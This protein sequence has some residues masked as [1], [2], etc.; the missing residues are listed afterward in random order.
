MSRYIESIRVEQGIARNLGF[1]QAR[2]QQTRSRCLGLSE[3]PQLQDWIE[4]PPEFRQGLAKCR[5]IYG[6]RIE[7]IDFSPYVRKPVTALKLIRADAITYG[8]KA[9]DRSLLE[10]LY[11]KRGDCDDILIIKQGWITDSYTANAVFWNGHHWHTPLHP[12]LPGTMRASLLARG[13]I[14]AVPLRIEHLQKYKKIRLINAFHSLE[15]APELD[16]TALTY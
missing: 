16:V 5:L 14:R 10:K 1:H 11:A 7:Q 4:P 3:H 12:L 2:F 15:E 13:L 9:E 8:Y 6:E